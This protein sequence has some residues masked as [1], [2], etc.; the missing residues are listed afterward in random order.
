M[1]RLRGSIRE[2]CAGMDTD[3]GEPG[4]HT[5]RGSHKEGETSPPVFYASD[6]R[7]M[8][9]GEYRASGKLW[10]AI[11]CVVVFKVLRLRT[12]G[13][14]DDIAVDKLAPFRVEQSELSEA[15]RAEF[16]PSLTELER[17][18][19]HSPRYFFVEDLHHRAKHWL[20]TLAHRS[21]PIAARI[22]RHLWT[23]P[24][25]PKST[26]FVEL[27]TEFPDGAVLLTLSSKFELA[28][29][30]EI[31]IVR[32][33]GAPVPELFKAHA[34][35]LAKHPS[36]SKA[37]PA[38]DISQAEQIFDHLHQTTVR[39]HLARKFFTPAPAMDVN[40]FEG[41]RNPDVLAEI[42]RL[43]QKSTTWRGAVLILIFSL[44][45][46]LGIGLPGN[47]SF[48]RLL[49]LVPILLF[50]EAGHYVAMRI[51]GYRNLKMFFIP[52]FG[53]AVTGRHYNV[54]GWKKVVVSLM[55]PVPGIVLGIAIGVGGIYWNSQL[56]MEAAMLMLLLNAFNLLPILPLDGGHV[57]RAV[58]FVRHYSLDVGFRVL[59]AVS[60]FALGVVLKSPFLSGIGAALLVGIPQLIRLAKITRA[61]KA[62]GFAP[63][64]GDSHTIPIAAG[65]R[66]VDELKASAKKP[67]H[68]RI[69]AQQ[70]MTVFENLNTRPPGWFASIA[71][72]GVHAAS[73]AAA[74]LCGIILVFA[75]RGPLRDTLQRM[76]QAPAHVVRAAEVSVRPGNGAVP[77]S[78]CVVVATFPDRKSAQAAFDR[79][80]KE[81]PD[82]GEIVLVGDSVFIALPRDRTE[83]ATEEYKALESA[84]A[85]VGYA[86][87][88]RQI[89]I[90]LMAVS[91]NSAA[92]DSVKNACSEYFDVQSEVPLVAPWSP[93]AGI[94]PA[95]H[96]ARKT[97][98]KL[99][100]ADYWEDP[101]LS[102]LGDR[103]EE[104]EDKPPTPETNELEAKVEA[105]KRVL[106]LE[107]AHAMAADAS[108]DFDQSIV[109]K[110]LELRESA[111][112]DE[113]RKRFADAAADALGTAEASSDMTAARWGVVVRSPF[114]I[115]FFG[116][117]FVHPQQGLPA[118]VKWL[119]N[120]GFSTIR[121]DV[122]CFGVP[123]GIEDG[124]NRDDAKPQ[125]P[126]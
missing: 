66:I 17:L 50:H 97:F 42:A 101:E 112:P 85:A 84:G 43:E 45:V 126:K 20:V 49:A 55:G 40:R 99:T 41:A 6:P 62:D 3:L 114:T 103:L 90:R 73:L 107:R 83:R 24:R 4:H 116:I 71:L 115:E 16:E 15:D 119:E 44:I 68:P 106:E 19:F 94:S 111:P 9:I 122:L 104:L 51:F 11:L 12:F 1:L 121:Y 123:P 80:S 52:G 18:G 48:L 37:K 125:S 76:A 78:H 120:K 21:R 79:Y 98:A 81:G 35:V 46:F 64:S 58:L 108:P 93:H 88:S 87:D 2:A 61:L 89:S 27:A 13:S 86:A 105:R 109:Q 54:A 8:S 70:A 110:F 82:S 5:I 33:V 28:S 69:L 14:P 10:Q 32:K 63:V 72:V 59:A 74:I 31:H 26:T 75:Q 22:H 92:A 102:K 77:Q 118:L 39:F 96:R 53:A 29:A 38:H 60:C 25:T 56:A 91:P 47:A 65:D 113:F 36:A 30:P 95:Q 117:T 67:T 34:E 100:S 7:A 124:E 57:V 23:L